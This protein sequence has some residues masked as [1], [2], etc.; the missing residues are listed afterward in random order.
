MFQ[1]DRSRGQKTPL[2]CHTVEK[3]KREKKGTD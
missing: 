1:P 2:F 3:R